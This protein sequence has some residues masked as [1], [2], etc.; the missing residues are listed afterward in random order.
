MTISKVISN[1]NIST[2]V[3]LFPCFVIILSSTF[4]FFSD[5]CS[6]RSNYRTCEAWKRAGWCSLGQVYVYCKKTCDNCGG[7]VVTRPPV[8]RPPVTRPPVTNPPR[9]RPPFTQGPPSGQ[10]GISSVQQ[11]RIVEGED[12]TKGAWPWI[13]SLQK[14]GSHF[15]GATLLST[16]WVCIFVFRFDFPLQ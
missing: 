11:G 10:C 8:T 1:M 15:C 14:S 6:D 9:T 2:L 16:R 5:A 13:A 4:L 7:G 3:V 12:A